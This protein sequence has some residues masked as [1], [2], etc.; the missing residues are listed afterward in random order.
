MK[1]LIL[2]IWILLNVAMAS[3]AAWGFRG[4]VETRIMDV[5]EMI[6]CVR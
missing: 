3:A 5:V 1:L 2:T 6:Q 4:I